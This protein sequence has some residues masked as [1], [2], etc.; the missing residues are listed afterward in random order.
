MKNSFS[1]MLVATLALV[2]VLGT[3]SKANAALF[4]DFENIVYD[5]GTITGG[6]GNVTGTDIVFDSIFLVDTA[7]GNQMGVQCGTG[8]ESDTCKLN[9]ST[10][11]NTFVLTAP[12]GLYDMG[13]DLIPYTADDGALLAGTDGANVLTGTFANSQLNTGLVLSQ[14]NGVGPDTKNP[15]LLTFFGLPLDTTFTFASTNIYFTADGSVINADLDNIINP[16]V[17]EPATMMLLGTGLL[18]AF[19]ARR[20][21]A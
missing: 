18:A 17:P 9:F 12:E 2:G 4:I 1:G 16:V 14:F 19:R 21:S 5:G 11:L 13:A 10:A 20:K 3:S 8:A 6:V 15:S 7:L